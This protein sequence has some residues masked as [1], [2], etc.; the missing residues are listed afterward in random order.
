MPR[1]IK[2]DPVNTNFKDQVGW[3][4]LLPKRGG[5]WGEG[6]VNTVGETQAEVEKLKAEKAALADRMKELDESI[7]QKM[8]LLEATAARA[9]KECT[10]LFSNAQIAEAKTV[11][12]EST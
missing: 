11:G 6:I 7:R 1:G 9:E 8:R 3:I 5:A 4:T 2:K 12:Q 10:M